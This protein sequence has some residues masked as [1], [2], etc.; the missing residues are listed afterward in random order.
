[1]SNRT[2]RMAVIAR[3]VMARLYSEGDERFVAECVHGIVMQWIDERVISED[4]P[5]LD[6]LTNT[7]AHISA[8]M[9]AKRAARGLDPTVVDP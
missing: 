7:L 6:L 9:Q 5:R 8:E 1:M 2:E 3:E 4:D